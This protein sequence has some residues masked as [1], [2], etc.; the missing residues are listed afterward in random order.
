[1]ACSPLDWTQDRGAT[2]ERQE[3][4]QEDLFSSFLS[5]Q[6]SSGEEESHWWWR[7]VV[8]S[9]SLCYQ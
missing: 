5:I 6:G 9:L 1:M 4:P 8:V 2:K 3:A 7:S